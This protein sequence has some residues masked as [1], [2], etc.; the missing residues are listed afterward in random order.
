MRIAAA[1][2]ESKQGQEGLPLR[3]HD[4][5]SCFLVLGLQGLRFIGLKRISFMSIF[6]GL[7]C[8]LLFLEGCDSV[9]RSELAGGAHTER[10]RVT[11]R[12]LSGKG[13]VRDKISCFAK[14]LQGFWQGDYEGSIRVSWGV[15]ILLRATMGR[16]HRSL[17]EAD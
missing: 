8:V 9:L 7:I 6:R 1:C 17:Q 15:A 11:V 14:L 10:G 4:M 3:D 12:V 2:S 13:S 5:R 16:K